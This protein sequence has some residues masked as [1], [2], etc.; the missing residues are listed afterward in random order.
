M[1]FSINNNLKNLELDR[2][3]NHCEKRLEISNRANGNL[4]IVEIIFSLL[5]NVE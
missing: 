3:F 1:G 2:H 4:G 5:V